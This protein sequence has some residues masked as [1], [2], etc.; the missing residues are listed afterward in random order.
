MA[1]AVWWLLNNRGYKMR[2]K[3]QDFNITVLPSSLWKFYKCY[4]ISEVKIFLLLVALFV[5]LYQSGGILAPLVDY[6]IIKLFKKPLP[7]GITLLRYVGWTLFCAFAVQIGSTIA[8]WVSV[9]L[10]AHSEPQTKNK[11]SEILTSYI[12]KQS[13]SFWTNKMSGSINSEINYVADGFGTYYDIIATICRALVIVGNCVC[14]TVINPRL[15]IFFV[16]AIGL[17]CWLTW[18]LGK[19]MVKPSEQIAKAQTILSGKLTDSFSN[20]VAVKYF[21]GTKQEEQILLEPRSKVMFWNRIKYKA[22]RRFSTLPSFLFGFI[23]VSTYGLSFLLYAYGYA[24]IEDM[25]FMLTAYFFV[26]NAILKIANGVPKIIDTLSKAKKAYKDLV[27]P[28]T[29]VDKPNAPDLIVNKGMI[30]F[31]HVVF[32]YRNRPVL[33]DLSLRIKPGERVGIVGASGAGKTTLVNLLMRFYEPKRG[34][35]LIDGQD[36]SDVKQDSLRSNIAFIPQ[37]PS[38]FNRTIGENIGYGK[39]G[40]TKAEI[41]KAAKNASADEFIMS[42]EKKYNSLVGDKG[43]KLSGGQRQRIAIARAFLKDAPILVLDEATSALDSETEVAIQESFEKLS[44]G[45]TTIAIAHRLSTLR[46]MDR[47][48]VLDKGVIVEQGTHQQLLRKK[49][50]YYQLWQMQ[51]GGFLTD[52]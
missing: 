14:I 43:I 44:K 2:V 24:K 21:A 18:S 25:T 36:I 5:L 29:I 9:V 46:N 34:Q 10:Q 49:G 3:Q 22:E 19:K 31:K 11:I 41:R 48:I 37:D 16:G 30:E 7:Q 50:K 28:I 4:A 33:E 39:T 6:E 1:N 45:R 23:Q 17:H 27:V 35:I 51:S 40:S 13:I 52:K 20:A 47:I 38:M 15:A 12:H 26:M 8:R 32:G 42:T